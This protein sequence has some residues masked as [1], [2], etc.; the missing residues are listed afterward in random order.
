MSAT[1]PWV[2]RAASACCLVLALFAS[3][4][5]QQQASQP[6]PLPFAPDWALIA[7]YSD[8]ERQQCP[9]SGRR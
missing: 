3:A 7:G 9:E 2:R 8:L 5:A 1:K 6:P 4:A